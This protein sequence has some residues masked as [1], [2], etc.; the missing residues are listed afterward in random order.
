MARVMVVGENRE[1]LGTLLSAGATRVVGQVQNLRSLVGLV[2]E[3]QAEV[4]VLLQSGAPGLAADQAVAQLGL[5]VPQ[6]ASILLV[7]VEDHA[8][9]PRRKRGGQ[10]ELVLKWPDDRLKLV[11]VLER[12]TVEKGGTREPP[13]GLGPDQPAGARVAPSALPRTAAAV[14]GPVAVPQI[15]SVI[16]PKGGVGKTTIAVNLAVAVGRRGQFATALLDLNL[17]GGDVAVHLDLLGGPTL[18]DL[19]PQAGE[20]TPELL[21][22]YLKV[23]QAS[24]LSVMTA[25]ER[26]ELAELVR[27]GVLARVLARVLETVG[28]QYRYVVLDHAPDFTSD[29]VCEALERSHLILLVS[30]LEA[31][32]LRQCRVSLE[33]LR[34]SRLNV[35]DRVRLV[36][37]QV[38]PAAALSLSEVERFMGMPVAVSIPE[39]RKAVDASIFNAQPLL[40]GE[41]G[42]VGR[43]LLGLSRLVDTG[44]A[45]PPRRV[46]PLSGV[47]EKLVRRASSSLLR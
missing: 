39:A 21:Q 8:W 5:L 2:G 38:Y 36:L 43:A 41:S 11:E 45:A 29:L 10:D 34:R 23:H 31:C 37:N 19:L 27:P 12:R 42:E 6:A 14:A 28:R 25:P 16:G 44:A 40:L 35:S 46:A 22:R 33:T 18:V 1:L 4:V 30:T 7:D 17:R 9:R 20:L 15:I 32:S 3:C 26:P 47:L 24:G 13:S